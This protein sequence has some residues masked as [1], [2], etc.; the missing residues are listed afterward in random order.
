MSTRIEYVSGLFVYGA[1]DSGGLI[2]RTLVSLLLQALLILSAAVCQ[3][4]EDHPSRTII[5]ENQALL[6]EAILNS[7]TDDEMRDKVKGILERFVDFKEFGRLCLHKHW[8]KL[9]ADQRVAYL[10]EFKELL[11]RTYLRR[12]KAGKDF[13]LE[14][15][16]KTRLNKT[17]DRA[18]VA[19]TITTDDVS[20]DV[21]YRFHQTASGWKV[22]DIIVD[23]VSIMRNY[24]KSFHKVMSRDGF[25][26]LL[27]KM[28]SKRSEDAEE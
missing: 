7:R 19:T 15:R 4:E 23:E 20:V 2:M 28:R 13:K 14:Y 10:E 5:Q 24:R 27:A 9:T 17:G 12:F 8:D 1:F 26:A 11:Q 22:Y 3:A 21:D 25:D 6:R 16:G 18:E